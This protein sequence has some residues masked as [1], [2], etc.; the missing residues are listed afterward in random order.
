MS[1]AA[2]YRRFG[3]IPFVVV[4]ITD[5]GIAASAVII[6][7]MLT[8]SLEIVL[9]AGLAAVV[10]HNWSVFL[11]F[12]GGLGATAIG[13]VLA[14]LVFWQSLVG[15]GIA[16]LVLLATRR[17]GL[18]TAVCII[19]ISGIL[20]MQKMP[21]VLAMYPITLFVLM[22]FKRVQRDRAVRAKSVN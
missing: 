11:R 21:A 4:V 20:F 5:M 3:P 8:G 17:S 10:G 7:K 15:L 13:G 9:V 6:A 19:I 1:A 2:M 16:G 22:L 14:S 18:S 12:K